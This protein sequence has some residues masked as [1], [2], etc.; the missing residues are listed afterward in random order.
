MDRI[1]DLLIKAQTFEEELP[2]LPTLPS[3]PE[4]R[5]IASWID[6]TL[7]K[8]DATIAQIKKLCEE[9]REYCFASVCINPAYVP[10]AAGL[11]KGSQVKVCTVVGFP[12][13]ATLPTQKVVE[14]LSCLN[15]G[16]TE[17]DMVMNIGALKSE[18]Y[19]QVMNEIQAVSQ[20]AQ[21]Q[22]A[23]VK[24]ILE[25]A[26]LTR[27]EKI[28]ASLISEAAG[29]DF[30]KTST[31]FGPG[32]ATVEDVDLMRRVVAPEVQVKAAGG[33][34]SLADAQAMIR[35]GASRL[36]ASAGVQIIKEASS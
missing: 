19:G 36:G 7:L 22:R 33:I 20:V 6:H 25:T 27:R 16:A 26:F 13:G 30:I 5:E 9:A 18:A 17:I 29:A 34:R 32:G 4:G 1:P 8:P 23:I 12:L 10:L 11:L 14:T 2:P 28:I 3:P 31:G 15:H 24:V 21:N 35:A